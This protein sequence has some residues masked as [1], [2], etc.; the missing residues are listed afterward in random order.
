MFEDTVPAH[1]LK[2]LEANP[3]MVGC[4][5]V[6]ACAHYMQTNSPSK[7]EAC[8]FANPRE[9]SGVLLIVALAILQLPKQK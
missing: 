6:R 2:R 8:G 1:I 5:I 9:A 3:K 4:E 7:L